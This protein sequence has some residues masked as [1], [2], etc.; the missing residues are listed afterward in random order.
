MAAVNKPATVSAG[1]AAQLVKAA[2][3]GRRYTTATGSRFARVE[4]PDDDWFVDVRVRGGRLDRYGGAYGADHWGDTRGVE[5]TRAAVIKAKAA[6]IRME[7][8][9]EACRIDAGRAGQWAVKA[10]G[11]GGGGVR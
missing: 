6:Q 7:Q 10:V 1:R 5:E 11:P 3:M 4:W 8:E 9:A 2:R